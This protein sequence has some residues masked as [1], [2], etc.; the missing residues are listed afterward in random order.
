MNH[1]EIILEARNIRL[2][3]AGTT[4]LDVSSLQVHKGEVLTFI[5]PNGAG[6]TTLL[7]TL[8]ALQRPREGSIFFRGVVVDRGFPLP[9]TGNW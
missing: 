4:V 8:C 5:G 3:R 7:M 2:E 1:T 9:P 6:K